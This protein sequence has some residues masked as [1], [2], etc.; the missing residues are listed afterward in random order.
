MT[1]RKV[2]GK[3]QTFHKLN[4][5]KKRLEKKPNPRR[6]WPAIGSDEKRR[7]KAEKRKGGGG[8]DFFSARR[9]KSTSYRGKDKSRRLGPNRVGPGRTF[10]IFH[11]VSH[12]VYQRRKSY[13][14]QNPFFFG[15][16]CRCFIHARNLFFS[17]YL[18]TVHSCRLAEKR[19][20]KVLM[21][22]FQSV[23]GA[24]DVS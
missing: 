7:K 1:E 13:A 24:R 14:L 8:N 11:V 4:F 12:S 17:Y 19:K 18:Y 15:Q 20:K 2:H 6:K 16:R 9:I 23:T 10:F 5:G 21:I 22:A 3:K